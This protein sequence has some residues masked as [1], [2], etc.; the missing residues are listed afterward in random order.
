MTTQVQFR[1]GTTAQHATFTGAIG[2]V[3]VDTTLDTIRVHDGA[4]AGGVRIAKYSEIPT[5]YDFTIQADDSAGLTITA[6]GTDTL[7][8]AGGNSITSS[9]DSAGTVIFDLDK[10]IDVNE[11]SS[12]DS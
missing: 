3:T 2:E 8:F 1:R 12:G 9:T 4:T 11:I 5:S 6:D 7:R 10:S